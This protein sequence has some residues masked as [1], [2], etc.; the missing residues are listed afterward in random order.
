MPFR[1]RA[2]EGNSAHISSKA[3]KLRAGHAPLLKEGEG[4]IQHRL[5]VP[6]NE[7]QIAV[8]Q[9]AR[10]ARMAEGILTAVFAQIGAQFIA[11]RCERL[12]SSLFRKSADGIQQKARHYAVPV[13]FV[14]QIA[15]SVQIFIDGRGKACAALID[16]QAPVGIRI[17]IRIEPIRHF[18]SIQIG[19][20]ILPRGIAEL[21][22][23]RV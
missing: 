2:V 3:V 8:V 13:I 10:K 19:T 17:F 20:G 22:Y 5:Q 1:F 14:N 7:V 21:R 18:G 9:T 6:G 12:F 11:K 4:S 15:L 16:I 23:I